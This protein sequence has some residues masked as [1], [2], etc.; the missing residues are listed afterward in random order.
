MRGQFVTLKL[1]DEV[2]ISQGKTGEWKVIPGRKKAD[3]KT[4]RK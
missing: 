1:K 3:T 2:T 4:L